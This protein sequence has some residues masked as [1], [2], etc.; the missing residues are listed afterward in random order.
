MEISK[1]MVEF[2]EFINAPKQFHIARD[3]QVTFPLEELLKLM[4][5]CHEEDEAEDLKIA[6]FNNMLMQT[7]TDMTRFV[8]NFKS[9]IGSAHQEEFLEEQKELAAKVV[10]SLPPVG[11]MNTDVIREV[12]RTQSEVTDAMDRSVEKA[13][14]RAK[15]T[16]TRNRPIQLA[17]K[18]TNFVESIDVNILLK[19]NDSELQRLR[20]QLAKLEEVIAQVKENL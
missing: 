20:R 5:K 3:M 14:T 17:E 7:S 10:E 16:E 2:L 15:K 11:K 9:I 8:R 13:I 19:M 4:K 6:V 18:A 12:V 1:L